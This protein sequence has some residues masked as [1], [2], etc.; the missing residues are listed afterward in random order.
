M[1][2]C[3]ALCNCGNVENERYNSI[4]SFIIEKNAMGLFGLSRLPLSALQQLQQTKKMAFK[5][6]SSRA[7]EIVYGFILY[8]EADGRHRFLKKV[9]R[10]HSMHRIN[11]LLQ[12]VKYQTKMT[13]FLQFKGRHATLRTMRTRAI[14]I[15]RTFQRAIN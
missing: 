10:R 6:P 12:H 3:L 13:Q 9:N 14:S 2:S 1:I 4:H 5:T 7:R 8:N 11:V 15:A